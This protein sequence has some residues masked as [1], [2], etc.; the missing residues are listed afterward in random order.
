MTFSYLGELPLKVSNGRH[1][2]KKTK[3]HRR[4]VIIGQRC[5][6]KNISIGQICKAFMVYEEDIN[7]DLTEGYDS[8][9][10]ASGPR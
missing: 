4:N 10:G 2:Y 8:M 9:K 7:L 6:R 1:M 3:Y 5:Y